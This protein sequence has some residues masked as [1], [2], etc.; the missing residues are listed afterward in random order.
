[1]LEREV[2]RGVA[3]AGGRVHR[4][5]L[6]GIDQDIPFGAERLR[7]H[8]R[9]PSRPARAEQHRSLRR[10][11]A[12]IRH[13]RERRAVL[14]RLPHEVDDTGQGAAAVHVGGPPAQHFHPPHRRARDAAPLH[15]ASEG[16]VD[17]HP[18]VQDESAARAARTHAA[19]ERAL[20]GGIGRTTA[21][22][23]EQ[24][25]PRHLAQG[26]VERH[27]RRHLQVVAREH[28]HARR[29]VRLEVAVRAAVTVSASANAAGRKAMSSVM[30]SVTTRSRCSAA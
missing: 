8:G 12:A 27:R 9:R 5:A 24:A 10:V 4:A 22:A 17:G 14:D 26:V 13:V 18:V 29:R 16:V 25:E 28:H 2:H 19:Q 15:P 7:G 23:A 3:G 30:P 21:G 1:M 6:E 11:L 20:G